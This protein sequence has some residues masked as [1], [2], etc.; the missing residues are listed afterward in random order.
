MDCRSSDSCRK[1][2]FNIEI[3]PLLSQYIL[4]LLLFLIKIMNQFMVNSEIY[5]IDTRQHANFHQTS[6]NRTKRYLTCFLLILKYSLIILRNWNWFY[7][8]YC[9]KIPFILW[10]NILNFKKVKFIYIW[11]KVV[12]ESLSHKIDIHLCFFFL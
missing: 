10:M 8:H 2:F 5:H 12:F 4:S 11:S 6:V 1:L 7:R 9:M 3:L